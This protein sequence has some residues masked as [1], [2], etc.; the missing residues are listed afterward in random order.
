MEQISY[1]GIIRLIENGAM[2]LAVK[3]LYIKTGKDCIPL[4]RS[5][6]RQLTYQEA[7]SI[8]YFAFMDLCERFKSGEFIYKNE[9]ATESYFK[10]SCINQSEK[11]RREFIPDML[12]PTG[13]FELIR[14]DADESI[15]EEEE[16]F[17]TEKMELGV[18]PDIINLVIGQEERFDLMQEVV[19]V[20]HELNDKCKFL[21]VLKFF[22]SLSH[23]QI[24]DSL[25]L[26]YG[27]SSEDVCKTDLYRC[28]VQI[29]KKINT[30]QYPS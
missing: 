24:V 30:S 27:I 5:R 28:L 26:F 15:R 21:I 7:L 13:F 22:L 14:E 25:H 6:L 11:Y 10:T 9:S 8:F 16:R 2:D 19:K 17:R 18:S 29:R 4:I 3:Q 20:F 23:R 12:V 1:S